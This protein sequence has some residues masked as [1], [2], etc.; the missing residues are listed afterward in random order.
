M[1]RGSHSS[2]ND[3]LNPY[4]KFNFVGTPETIKAMKNIGKKPNTKPLMNEAEWDAF[5]KSRQKK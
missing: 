3:G 2:T 5:C 4:A 1:N